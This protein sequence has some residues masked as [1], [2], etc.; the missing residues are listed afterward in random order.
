MEEK[1][2][3]RTYQVNYKCDACKD[4]YLIYNDHIDRMPGFIRY[5]HSCSNKKCVALKYL[6]IKYPYFTYE[7]GTPISDGEKE[8]NF[9]P[10]NGNG[11]KPN[12]GGK[13]KPPN[14]R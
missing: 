14:K 7:D 9:K 12:K 10:N 13:G 6:D 8:P 4:G 2:E 5:Q 11:Y 3:V 1:K